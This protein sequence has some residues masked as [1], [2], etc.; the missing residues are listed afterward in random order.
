MS[1]E[2][3]TTPVDLTAKELLLLRQRLA[4]PGPSGGFPGQGYPAADS[5]LDAKLFR[6]QGRLPLPPLTAPSGS[7][8]EE[9]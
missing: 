4:W 2:E 3:P 6:A 8:G 1:T 5:V 9:T 7:T